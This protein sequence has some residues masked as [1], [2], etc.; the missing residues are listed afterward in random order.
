MPQV[1]S[2]RDLIVWQR[3]LDLVDVCYRLTWK[4]PPSE[5]YGLQSQI[6]RAAISVPANIAEG[7][8]RYTRGDFLRGL[9]IANGSLKELETHCLVAARLQLLPAAELEPAL[10]LAGEVGRMIRAIRRTLESRERL[11]RRRPFKP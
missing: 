2:Y 11:P 3:S 4:L 9:R 10:A 5:Q 6:R 7:H 1:R 8:G